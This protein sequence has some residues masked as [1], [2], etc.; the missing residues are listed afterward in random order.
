MF[1]KF[2]MWKV[3]VQRTFCSTFH[4]VQTLTCGQWV[5]N[6]TCFFG[7]IWLMG[8]VPQ[9]CNTSRVTRHICAEWTE[10]SGNASDEFPLRLRSLLFSFGRR[11]W[12]TA[13]SSKLYSIRCRCGGMTM[14]LRLCKWILIPTN[15]FPRRV[16]LRSG[17]WVASLSSEG[18]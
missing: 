3:V 2:P 4:W 10:W 1:S 18:I 13:P 6:V 16:Q 11:D 15:Q 14:M 5:S 8:F 7:L 12:L 9:A 17:S